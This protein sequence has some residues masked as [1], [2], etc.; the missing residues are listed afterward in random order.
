MIAA[1]AIPAG[2]VLARQ[3]DQVPQLIQAFALFAPGIAGTAVITN[4][5]G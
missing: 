2:H 4:C 5:R 1:I 3:P